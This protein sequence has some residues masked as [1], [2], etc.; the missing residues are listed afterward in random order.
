MESGMKSSSEM[1]KKQ[2]EPRNKGKQMTR[3]LTFGDIASYI[4]R[5]LGPWWFS[6]M[7]WDM[8]RWEFGSRRDWF[9]NCHNTNSQNVKPRNPS[10][11]GNNLNFKVAFSFRGYSTILTILGKC[12][13]TSVQSR[14]KI[15]M[16]HHKTWVFVI[17]LVSNVFKAELCSERD[18]VVHWEPQD[19]R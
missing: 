8:R 11:R 16:I 6:G 1:S 5:Y 14:L 10:I 9:P 18:S 12:T 2:T 19:S 3:L 4:D 7:R 17:F 13:L 15:K